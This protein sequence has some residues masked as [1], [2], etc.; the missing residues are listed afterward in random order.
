MQPK[1]AQTIKYIIR[2]GCATEQLEG[3]AD[4]LEYFESVRSFYTTHRRL[5]E[6]DIDVEVE[7]GIDTQ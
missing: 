3:D 6:V 5:I 2:H 7:E 4:S 1:F